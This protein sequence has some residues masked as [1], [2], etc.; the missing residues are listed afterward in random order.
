MKISIKKTVVTIG[1]AVMMMTSAA[2]AG[3]RL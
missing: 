2:M 3:R 1:F